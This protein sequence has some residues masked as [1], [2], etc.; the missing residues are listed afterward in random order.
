M[1]PEPNAE[2]SDFR[3]LLIL[4]ASINMAGAGIS[5]EIPLVVKIT[6]FYKITDSGFGVLLGLTTFVMAV[7]GVPWGYWADKYKRIRLIM[8]SQA[9]IS[10]SII[11]SGLCLALEL[12]YEVFFAV[13][14][15]SGVGLAGIGPVATSAVIDTVPLEKRGAAFGW[16][17]V[18]WVSG[19]A[20]GMLLPAL[21]MLLKLSLGATFLIGGFASLGFLAALFF[22][23]EPKRGS[24]DQALKDLGGTGPV[25]YGHRIQA[26]ELKALL[27]R[28]VNILLLFVMLFF[29]FPQQV[30][31]VWFVTFL[32]RNH[33]LSE[34]IA[35]QLMFLAFLGMPFGNAFGG[36]WIDAA[37]KKKRTGRTM[38]MIVTALI[39]PVFLVAAMQLPFKWILF[40]PL[41][42]LANFFMVASGPGLTTV[43]LEVNLPEHRGTISAV[44]ALCASV[45][46][47][48]AWYVPPM[49][50]AGFGGWYDRGIV[51]TALAYA[52]LVLGYIL[53]N[54]RIEKDLD[55]V[56]NT[57]KERTQEFNH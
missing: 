10:A 46:R 18:S 5:F 16:V 4:L 15:L 22:V 28:P 14:L 42:I 47:G 51:F 52:P 48:L 29:Q 37:F 11:L 43:S 13:K 44:L 39:A 24:R 9:I 19:G 30:T 26:S 12:P 55:F 3:G 25:E 2:K 17:G 36:A 50:A 40:A 53:I 49:I 31:S 41:M 56:N 23:E 38:V 54:R 8:L 45:A 33:G 7:A 20:A 35:T 1:T 57:L 32:I 21:C 34:F 6:G 27:T